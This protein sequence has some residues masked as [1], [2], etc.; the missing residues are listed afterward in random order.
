MERKSRGNT[1]KKRIRSGRV[2]REDVTRRLAEL[3]FGSANDGV[4]L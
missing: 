2:R 4:C 3:A 1:L